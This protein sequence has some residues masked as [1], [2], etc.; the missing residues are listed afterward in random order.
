MLGKSIQKHS[1]ILAVFA[2][3]ITTATALTHRN[4]K[5]IIAE[6]KRAAQARALIEIIPSERHDNAILDDTLPVYDPV[7]LNLR[8]PGKIHIARFKGAPVA[9]ILPAVA[10]DGYSGEIHLIV[11]INVDGTVAGVR[12]LAHRETPGL[13]DKVDTKKSDWV[14]GFNNR[15]L[16]NPK[17]NKWKVKRDKGI[18]DQFTGATITPR[19]ITKS[20]YQALLY[21]KENQD[22]IFAQPVL[23]PM[24]K[25]MTKKDEA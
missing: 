7:F 17:P 1:L 3:V 13:G 4:T 14:L 23:Q 16:E 19:A 9:A 5:D 12:I 25:T 10:P 2:I 22:T 24:S 18:F 8:K 15:S 20:V 21:F 6:Q 11:G